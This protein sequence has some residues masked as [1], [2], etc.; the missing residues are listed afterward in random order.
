MSAGPW[1]VKPSSVKNAVEAVLK[2]GMNVARVEFGRN[3]EFRVIV[4]E[5][6]E[7]SNEDRQPENEW[8]AV[9]VD[10]DKL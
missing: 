2:A 7:R 5:P 4:G 6:S 8:D 1:D 3:G 10:E 9:L